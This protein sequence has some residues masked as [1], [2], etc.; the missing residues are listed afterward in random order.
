MIGFPVKVVDG[1]TMA[2]ITL[3]E[4]V[5]VDKMSARMRKWYKQ[6]EKLIRNVR[7]VMP[8]AKTAAAY[9]E[10]IDRQV[11]GIKNEKIRK[12]FYKQQEEL[13]VRQYEQEMRKLTF[14]QGKLLIKLIDRETGRSS[15]KIIAEYRSSFTAAFWQGFARVFGYNLKQTYD[16][17]KDQDIE[18]VIKLL[19]YE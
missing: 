17:D 5:I 14:S 11:S 6:N 8:Y 18:L 10:Q 4:V 16:P 3:R 19:G 12:Q 7:I 2:I 9:L 13:L 15:Y 1:D